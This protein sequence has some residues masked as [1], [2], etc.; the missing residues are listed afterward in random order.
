MKPLVDHVPAGRPHHGCGQ[1]ARSR[2]SLGARG[3]VPVPPAVLDVVDRPSA[4]FELTG[5]VRCSDGPATRLVESILIA[6]HRGGHG[7][8]SHAINQ[9]RIEPDRLRRTPASLPLP[10]RRT[11]GPCSRWMPVRWLRRTPRV[12]R[13]PR[14]PPGTIA[15]PRKH[16]P[17][18][19]TAPRRGR[20]EPRAPAV[21]PPRLPDHPRRRP[22][23][24]AHA[25]ITHMSARPSLTDSA[26][27]EDRA[28]SRRSRPPVDRDP[29]GPPPM[30]G[31][32][33]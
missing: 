3:P 5:A 18:I 1:S 8:M 30:A 9:G 13:P 33:C 4:S 12:L 25:P 31:P 28:E 6:E 10:Q 15:R 2:P 26:Q 24:L 21:D 7:A 27:I 32:T 22:V 14:Q 16:G 23:D 29:V 19:A 17:K 11:G 20:P